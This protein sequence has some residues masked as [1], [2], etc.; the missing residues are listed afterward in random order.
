MLQQKELLVRGTVKDKDGIALPG[1]TVQV[2]G[3]TQGTTT[4][5]DGEYY[6][7]IKN[8]EKPILVF[9]F[10]GMETVEVPFEKGKHRINVT[11]SE[12]QQVM[13]EV[14]VNGIFTRKAESFTG[15]AKTFKKDELKRV[16]NGNVFQSLKNLD[17]SSLSL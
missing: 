4:D 15:S 1:V 12:S 13:D 14:V 11:L 9:S 6:I 3:T 10:I 5:E 7:M 8:V 16:G 2:K 17:A